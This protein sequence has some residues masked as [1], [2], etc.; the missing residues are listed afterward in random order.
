[1]S[2]LYKEIQWPILI[3]YA[4]YEELGYVADASAWER[5]V[6]PQGAYLNPDD[7]LVD[8]AGISFSASDA[9]DGQKVLQRS[10][11]NINLDEILNWVRAHASMQGHCCVAKLYAA[12]IAEVFGIL[13][14][15]DD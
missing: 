13:K 12:S 4:N 11:A 3:K 7:V 10:Q 8:S 1:M 2:D 9:A 14:S 6:G 5:E 15:L